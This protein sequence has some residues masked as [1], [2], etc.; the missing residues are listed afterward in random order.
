L[1]WFRRESL[2][3]RLAREG[4][5]VEARPRAAWEEVGIHGIPRPREWDTVVTVDAPDVAGNEVAFVSL[6]D[7]SLIVEDEQGDAQLDPLANAVEEQL[8]PPYRARAVRRSGS[9]WAVSAQRIRIEQFE[10][11][12]DSIELTSTPDGR[13]LVVDGMPSFGTVPALE[14]LGE[15]AGPAYAVHAERLDGDLW[16]VRVAA[17]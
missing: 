6:A 4:G 11:S 16:D 17:L 15:A 1:G 3:E 14:Q 7:G 5:L 10:A 13:R 9:L 2:H 12:G 8:A